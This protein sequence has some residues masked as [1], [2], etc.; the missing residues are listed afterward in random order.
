MCERRAAYRRVFID[1][2]D[3]PA[4]SGPA[5]RGGGTPKR[6]T[7]PA[8][9]RSLRG[10][11]LCACWCE[12]KAQQPHAGNALV[13]DL[14]GSEIPALGGLDS[15][16]AEKLAGSG[17][18]FGVGHRAR[19]VHVDLY[20]DAHGAMNCA[21]GSGRNLWQD[22]VDHSALG[23]GACGNRSWRRRSCGNWVGWNRRG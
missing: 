23:H 12:V 5:L 4:A 16:V 13:R 10:Q 1:P 11:N 2:R 20:N 6:R 7:A 3:A 22:L 9:G 19:R 17:S 8:S 18:R 21:P 15:R 14:C